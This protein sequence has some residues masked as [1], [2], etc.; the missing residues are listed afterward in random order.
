MQPTCLFFVILSNASI[1]HAPHHH[2]HHHHIL[3]LLSIYLRFLVIFNFKS[4]FSVLIVIVVLF[5]WFFNFCNRSF[6]VLFF[7]HSPH[8]V[9]T[10]PWHSLQQLENEQNKTETERRK[11]SLTELF[12]TQKMTHRQKE[13]WVYRYQIEKKNPHTH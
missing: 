2:H 3:Y 11:K 12:Y 7:S 9:W 13:T 6:S 4:N 5:T 1:I 10:K 8:D